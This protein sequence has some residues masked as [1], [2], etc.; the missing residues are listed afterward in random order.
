[1]RV[2]IKAKPS[3]KPLHAP[4]TVET[5]TLPV[6]KPATLFA[7]VLN[8]NSINRHRLGSY[9]KDNFWIHVSDLM[10]S[11]KERI[12]CAREQAIN[13]HEHRGEEMIRRITPAMALLHSM[14]HSVQE[15]LTKKFVSESEFGH[16]LWGNWKCACG[17]TK[18]KHCFK[19]EYACQECRGSVDT[20]EEITLVQPRYRLVGHPDIIVL[21]NKHLYIYE[22][23]SIDRQSLPFDSIN[24]PLGDHTLQATFY[25]WM[26]L[27]MF[28]R[29][30]LPYPPHDK[31]TYLYVDRSNQ[32]LFFGEPYKE[33]EKRRSEAVRL[34]PMLK[35]AETLIASLSGSTLPKRICE[36]VTCTRARNCTVQVSCFNRSSDRLDIR[37]ARR[38]PRS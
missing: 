25:Y 18:A 37:N 22:V 33:F 8:R 28:M 17:R 13:F 2:P 31:I 10:Q 9:T 30:E 14:G 5:V 6:N 7:D 21:W 23:K 19:P 12:F 16:T 32:K 36:E 26:A 38:G 35:R 34:Q 3:S 11:S 15:H 4:A 24:E 20:Y 29:G 27:D 1:M